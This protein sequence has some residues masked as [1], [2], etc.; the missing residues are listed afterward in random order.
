MP[1]YRKKSESSD[2]SSDESESSDGSSED[3][4][5]DVSDS[6]E[7]TG[8]YKRKGKFKNP[9]K[10][11]QRSYSKGSSYNTNRQQA[12]VYV[13]KNTSTN[14]IYVGKSENISNRIQ[15]HME[16]NRPAI[17]TQERTL[18][19]GSVADLE[20]W[21]RN[22]VLTRMYSD[23]MES[24]RGW[25]Y[26]RRGA[27]TKEEMISAKNDIVEKFDLC[28]RCGHNTH[29]A[30]KCFARTPASWCREIPM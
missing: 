16:E 23:G 24:V 15:Q 14:V 11:Y 6:Q 2:G 28:R 19:N 9:K 29:F 4:D 10:K 5:S 27:L 8:R 21:E 18:T 30:D 13:L 25:R 20:S 7:E 22:E 17:M 1:Y 26:T 3:D 12:G